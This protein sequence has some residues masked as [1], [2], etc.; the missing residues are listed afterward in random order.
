M[1]SY[2]YALIGLTALL[3]MLVAILAFAAMRFAAAAK[4][5]RRHL[6]ESGER[7]ITIAPELTMLF[8]ATIRAGR[9]RVVG[10]R[11]NTHS[12]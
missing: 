6:R 8:A 12:G 9:S 2:A 5:A 11:Q 10:P 1:N 4:D 3:A 7:S